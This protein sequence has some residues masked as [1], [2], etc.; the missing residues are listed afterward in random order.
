MCGSYT[1]HLDTC[2]PY[3]QVP[4]CPEIENRDRD[5]NLNPLVIYVYMRLH[6]PSPAS[7]PLAIAPG[8]GDYIARQAGHVEWGAGHSIQASGH[9]LDSLF[10]HPPCFALLICS[11]PHPQ[12]QQ[13]DGRNVCASVGCSGEGTRQLSP[14][15]QMWMGADRVARCEGLGLSITCD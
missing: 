9:G 11:S 15:G 7:H 5:R 6:S 12:L 3:H 8:I 1:H 13:L 14:E 2:L 4:V 10:P